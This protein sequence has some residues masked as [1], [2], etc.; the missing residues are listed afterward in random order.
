MT[1]RYQYE[2]VDRTRQDLLET[3]CHLVESR[4]CCPA[5]SAK[6]FLLSP[7]AGPAEVIPASLKRSPLWRDFAFLRLFINMRVQTAQDQDTA[8]AV[9]GFADYLLRVGD[10]RHETCTELGSDY[11][12]IP[13]DMLLDVSG[14]ETSVVNE[15]AEQGTA[16]ERLSR[17]IEKVYSGF[18]GG[19]Q[20]DSYFADRTILTPKNADVLAINYM[21]HDKLPGDAEE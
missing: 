9:H 6:R 17:L 4:C 8:Q 16:P 20:P 13:S 15:A 11:V 18:G 14:L 2:A 19:N 3:I 1:H 5:T 12:K 21:I 10:G 7:R